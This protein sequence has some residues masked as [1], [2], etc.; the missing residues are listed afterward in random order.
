MFSFIFEFLHSTY[1]LLTR[2]VHIF[3]IGLVIVVELHHFRT[4]IRTIRPGWGLTSLLLWVP[5][6]DSVLVGFAIGHC[7]QKIGLLTDLAKVH[8]E[9][10]G[11]FS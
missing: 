10:F 5:G 9:V 8:F 7:F 11:L 1:E 3:V 6:L 4:R 2:S